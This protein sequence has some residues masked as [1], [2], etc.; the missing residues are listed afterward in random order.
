VPVIIQQ[1]PN[2][3]DG[4]GMARSDVE[5]GFIALTPDIDKAHDF[6][7]KNLAEAWMT[8][9]GITGSVLELED[10]ASESE[11]QG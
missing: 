10:D 8:R 1:G 2:Y 6:Q 7:E 3:I 5:R 11:A 9:K 4:D